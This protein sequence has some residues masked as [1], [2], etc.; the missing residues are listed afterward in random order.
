MTLYPEN[1]PDI[2]IQ[3]FVKAIRTQLKGNYSIYQPDEYYLGPKEG[4]IDARPLADIWRKVTAIIDPNNDLPLPPGIIVMH[5]GPLSLDGKTLPGN[6]AK[7]SITNKEPRYWIIFIDQT[8]IEKIASNPNIGFQLPMMLE[9]KLNVSK[10]LQP[11][12]EKERYSFLL[13]WLLAHEFTHVWQGFYKEPN[14][15][16]AHTILQLIQEYSF[17]IGIALSLTEFF[18]YLTTINAN[19]ER[20]PIPLLISIAITYIAHIVNGVYSQTEREAI[21]TAFKAI[22]EPTNYIGI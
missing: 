12:P 13:E 16:V 15:D 7:M 19:I 20:I 17:S 4:E 2:H 10:L 18:H 1:T 6:I 22:K 9:S 21:E 5:Q 14:R 11:I 8:A 3:Q